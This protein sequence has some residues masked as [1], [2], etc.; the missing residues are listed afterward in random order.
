MYPPNDD[1]ELRGGGM[2]DP[3]PS[4]A[5]DSALGGSPASSGTRATFELWVGPFAGRALDVV[6]FVGREAISKLFAFDVLVVV[7]EG[8]DLLD[9]ALL[10]LPATFTMQ[11]A[12]EP[13]RIVQGIIASVELGAHTT[14]RGKRA[15]ELRVVPRLW[16]LKKR[17]TSRIFQDRTVRRLSASCSMVRACRT[18]STFCSRMRSELIACSTVRATSRSS[19]ESPP[20]RASSGTSS[21]Q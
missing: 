16:Q 3:F 15:F 4:G 19:R 5:L 21:I 13:P 7:D 17:I 12:G 8:E 6:S 14:Y 18:P 10:G 11:V 9:R 20:K 1:V 2:S